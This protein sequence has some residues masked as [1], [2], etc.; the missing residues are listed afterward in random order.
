M[1][2]ARRDGRPRPPLANARLLGLEVDFLWPDQRLVVEVDGYTFHGHR[3]G[4]ERDRRRDQ[5]LVAAGYRVIRVTWR[6]L[7]DEPIAVI[8]SIAQALRWHPLTG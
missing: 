1:R 6:Q 4:F 8:A 3:R 7:R 5:Q 2:R